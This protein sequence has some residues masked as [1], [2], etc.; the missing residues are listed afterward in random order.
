MVILTVSWGRPTGPNRHIPTPKR[1]AA[2]IS[3]P[4]LA[5]CPPTSSCCPRCSPACCGSPSW[6][7]AGPL[8]EGSLT[9]P[10]MQVAIH[11]MAYLQIIPL[12]V[13][14]RRFLAIFAVMS[15]PCLCITMRLSYS[16][17]SPGVWFP[18]S[19]HHPP[20]WHPPAPSPSRAPPS[21]VEHLFAELERQKVG[22][23]RQLAAVQQDVLQPTA[24]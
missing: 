1:S 10:T 12:L 19:P 18:K 7:L 21:T 20:P 6:A 5:L 14:Y 4:P 16:P 13:P 17:D 22:A 15:A 24:G 3:S 8:D 23:A 2:E 9:T 11:A